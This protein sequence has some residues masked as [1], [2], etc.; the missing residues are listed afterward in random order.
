MKQSLVLDLQRVAT[1]KG[2]DV[3]DLLRKALV[4]ATKLKID[5]FREWISRELYGYETGEVP[6]YRR[7]HCEMKAMNP[8]HGLIPVFLPPELGEPLC[9][10]EYRGSVGSIVS[11]LARYK[12]DADR[13][14]PVLRLSDQQKSALMGLMDGPPLEPVRIVSTTQLETIV[15]AVRSTVLEWALKLEAAGIVGS[16]MSF[17]DEEKIRAAKNAQV[18]IHNFQGVLGDVLGSQVT[19]ALQMRID[20]GDLQGLASYLKS[21]GV[22][23]TDIQELEEAIECDP[24]PSSEEK[25]GARVSQWVGKMISKAASGAWAMSVQAASGLLTN[26]IWAY[27]RG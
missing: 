2:N 3:A 14:P 23:D 15:D 11:T 19:Q 4:V 9:N 21:Q 12:G 17:S 16:G 8:Y 24:A 20:I 13:L 6:R 1:D 5:D 25:L 18:H 27:Y 10:V 26:A 7:I 22:A